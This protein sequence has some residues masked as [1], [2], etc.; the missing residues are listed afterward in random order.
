ML[1][2]NDNE[3]YMFQIHMHNAKKIQSCTEKISK[4]F[5]TMIFE[6]RL[7]HTKVF[8]CFKSTFATPKK[9]LKGSQTLT[10]SIGFDFKTKKLLERIANIDVTDRLSW[11]QNKK[12]LFLKVFLWKRWGSALTQFLDG[13]KNIVLHFL[14][15]LAI[16]KRVFCCSYCLIFF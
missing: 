7:Y 10:Q 12:N 15:F 11:K 13:K 16:E 1:T 8:A 4:I 5:R 6:R 9:L 2:P 3:G 14:L